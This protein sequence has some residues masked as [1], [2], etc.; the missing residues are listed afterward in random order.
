MLDQAEIPLAYVLERQAPVRNV[1]VEHVANVD[2]VRSRGVAAV[3]E[4]LARP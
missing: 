1:D 3:D 4:V 2:G